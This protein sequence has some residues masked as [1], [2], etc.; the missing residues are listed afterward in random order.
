MNILHAF[1]LLPVLAFCAL[2]ASA[3]QLSAADSGSSPPAPN[4][5][6][7]AIL[8]QM[9]LKRWIKAVELTAD[10]QK[11]IQVLL[12]DE[13]KL[14]AKLKEDQTLSITDRNDKH[15]AIQQ[16]TYAKI[17]PLLTPEQLVK[18]EALMTKPAKPPKKK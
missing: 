9:R 15:T 2:I 4:P 8:N 16:E 17:K 13:A 10:Q 1:R 7:Q 5:D 12:D 14:V 6:A 3:P 11:K 18:W